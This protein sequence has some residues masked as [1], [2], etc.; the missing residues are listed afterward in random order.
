MSLDKHIYTY[1]ST[2]ITQIG[3]R[4]IQHR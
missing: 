1:G 4:E 3:L 2:F